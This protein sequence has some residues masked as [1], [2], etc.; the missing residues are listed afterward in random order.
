MPAGIAVKTQATPPKTMSSSSAVY[1]LYPSLGT[2][3]CEDNHVLV[4]Y[5]AWAI[6]HHEP[7][8][9]VFKCDSLGNSGRYGGLD[10][11]AAEA[12]A[13]ALRIVGRLDP[14]AAL[15]NLGN[16]Y[17][18]V[19]DE[20]LVELER[21]GKADAQAYAQKK[22]FFKDADAT[23]YAFENWGLFAAMHLIVTGQRTSP[24]KT[25]NAVFKKAA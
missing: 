15:A 22:L 16:G 23:E 8:T 21:V 11:G 14:D 10:G 4:A 6:D 19:S 24:V 2:K 20:K 9:T 7:E 5:T 25:W 17:L 3:D 12:I 13:A 18:V 1:R